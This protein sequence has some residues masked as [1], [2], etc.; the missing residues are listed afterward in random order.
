MRDAIASWVLT[1]E[2][3]G[4][5]VPEP[6]RP[7]G[8]SGRWLMRVPKS[9]HRRLAMQAKGEGVSLNALA[10]ALLAEGLGRRANQ[11]H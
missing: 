6:S 8:Y 4:E 5:R 10:T 2:E 1:S 9:M 7:H 3:L 11:H